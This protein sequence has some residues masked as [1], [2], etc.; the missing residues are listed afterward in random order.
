MI[1]SKRILLIFISILLIVITFNIGYSANNYV[2]IPDD[3]QTLN[4]ALNAVADGG[5]IYIRDSGGFYAF[6]KAQI[7]KSVSIIG[8][9]G[10]PVIGC[11]NDTYLL[12]EVLSNSSLTIENIHFKSSIDKRIIESYSPYLN[13]KDVSFSYSDPLVIKNSQANEDV[14]ITVT[15]CS[16]NPK[17][18]VIDFSY[19]A[20]GSISFVNSS[21]SVEGIEVRN[22]NGSNL[23][24][25]GNVFNDSGIEIQGASDSQIEVKDNI[26]DGNKVIFDFNDFSTS[27]L[28]I[29]HNKFLAPTYYIYNRD[30]QNTLNL[31]YNWWNSEDGPSIDGSSVFNGNIIYDKWALD[32][33]FIHFSGGNII[34][35]QVSLKNSFNHGGIDVNLFLDGSRIDSTYTDR[36]GLF[37]FNNL[38]PNNYTLT[39][40]NN[41][42]NTVAKEV[43]IHNEDININTE[44]KYNSNL[45]DVNNDAN[46]DNLDISEVS[47]AFGLDS[48]DVNW[49]DKYDFNR[50]GKIDLLDIL[51]ILR[52]REDE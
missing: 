46:V 21:F 8:I 30:T 20:N 5:T 12:I 14:D 41:G 23:Y 6:E 18:P 51:I 35:G 17:G 25:N 39:F 16:F 24:I 31:N 3:Y 52:F 50:N 11:K 44:L 2:T 15:N 36:D 48:T 38:G 43:Y 45:L 1:G 49:R 13:L 19:N 33:N 34:E 32:E 26:F 28:N 42:Y 29:S 10:T 4:D 37:S 27:N 22:S 7:D 47:N 9:D 40:Q